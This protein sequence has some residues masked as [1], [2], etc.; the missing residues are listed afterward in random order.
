MK[1]NTGTTIAT[2]ILMLFVWAAA[3]VDSHVETEGKIKT[4]YGADGRPINRGEGAKGHHWLV[5]DV[6]LVAGRATV[7]LNTSTVNGLQDV[8]FIA[9]S[10]YSV[11]VWSLDTS[12]T[13]TYRGR[14]LSGSK[15]LITSSS[16][17]DTAT[18][19]W[20]ANGE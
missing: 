8:S 13:T 9:D 2:L 16:G 5:G 14:P 18:V 17:S 11:G 19:R 10:T 4:Q 12:N 7:T 20:K 1:A 15:F 3:T 6:K